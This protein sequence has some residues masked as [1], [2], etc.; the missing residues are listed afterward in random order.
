M[1]CLIVNCHPLTLLGLSALITTI[2]PSWKVTSASSAQEA[3]AAVERP[4]QAPVG[5][6]I[7]YGIDASHG[8]EGLLAGSLQCGGGRGAAHGMIRIVFSAGAD[9]R[10]LELCRQYAA[11]ACTCDMENAAAIIA[12]I[13]A[14]ASEG[15]CF[16][17]S[18]V[19]QLRQRAPAPQQ[20]PAA[21]AR[22]VRA[23]SG[24][25]PVL[26]PRQ[27]ELA[28]MVLAGY[29]NK[30]IAQE[31]DLSYGTVKNYMVELMRLL[32]VR[33]RLEMAMRLRQSGQTLAP[34]APPAALQPQA[35]RLVERR[36]A[37]L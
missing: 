4:G 6:L 7:A 1:H 2:Y 18:Q 8:L 37:V 11:R 22:P 30:K 9:Q 5:L 16:C 25:M 36:S 28:H 20:L 13:K 23:L 12:S 3:L 15:A 32:E 19:I 29:S 33:S 34:A 17:H 14:A 21:S 27:S 26:T 24:G 35:L 10:T 31:L